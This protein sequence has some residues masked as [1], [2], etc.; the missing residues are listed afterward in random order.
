MIYSWWRSKST[1]LKHCNGHKE[2]KGTCKKNHFLFKVK[3]LD[4][5][6]FENTLYMYISES[7]TNI[8]FSTII[9]IKA[10]T[11]I[12]LWLVNFNGMSTHRGLFSYLKVRESCSFYFHIYIFCV[13]VSYEGFCLQFYWKWI[14]FKQI[15]FLHRWVT[16]R[17][18]Y[19]KP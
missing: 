7:I 15:Y 8:Y 12:L 11:P 16:K 3:M 2:N 14:I 1:L 4:S 17:Y 9:L 6:I 18:H 5:Y 19:S 13:I 10:F